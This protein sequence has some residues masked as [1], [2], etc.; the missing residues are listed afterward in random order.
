MNE[1][2]QELAEQAGMKEIPSPTGFDDFILVFNKEK[3]AELLIQECAAEIIKLNDTGSLDD[4]DR[5][6]AA[7]LDS[8]F[9]TIKK[10]FGVEE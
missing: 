3:F 2:I 8:A 1:R 6:Y 9:R 10:H 5:G 7:G 4:W